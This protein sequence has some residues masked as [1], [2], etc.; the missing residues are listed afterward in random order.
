MKKRYYS[1]RDV[2]AGFMDLQ[3]DVNDDTAKR[4]FAYAVNNVETIAFAPNDFDLYFV[5]EFD[6]NSGLFFPEN[7]PVLVA[8]GGEVF[9]S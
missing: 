8:S 6:T 4:N 1:I 9:D 2:K 7:I 5:G 3:P